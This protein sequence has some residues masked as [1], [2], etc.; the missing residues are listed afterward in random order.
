MSSYKSPTALF[1]FELTKIRIDKM[2]K[3][4][5][6]D[7]ADYKRELYDAFVKSY[8]TDKDLVDSYGE[9][10]SLNRSRDEKDKDP[11]PSVGSDRGTKRR[12][13]SKEAESSRDS[14]SKENKYSSTL[15]TPPILNISHLTSL[16]MQMS[17][18]ILLM[19][20]D[21]NRIRSLTRVTMMNNSLT[22]RLP[23]MTGSRNSSDLLLLIL[24]GIRD[25]VLTS[26][27]LRP[28]LV[29]LPVLKNLLL[30][31]MSS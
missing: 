8:Q 9:V 10:F 29:K 12:K 28:G 15:K 30:H 3:T 4:K 19:T 31:L 23:R 20:Q 11:D 2:E 21:C 24:I 16:P 27:H 7:K 25:N 1:E 14:R 18:V 6:F 17:Q 22:R 5:L 26:D 13:A